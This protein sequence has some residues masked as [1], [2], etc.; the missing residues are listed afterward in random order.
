MSTVHN[1]SKGSLKSVSAPRSLQIRNNLDSE[2]PDVYTPEVLDALKALSVFNKDQKMLMEKRYARRAQRF[3]N[4]ERIRFLNPNDFIPRTNIKVQDARDGKFVGSEIPHDLQRQWIQGTGPAAKPK[5]SIEKSIRNVA[6]AL[7]SGADG[8]MFDGEDALGQINSMSLD[9]QRN[10]KLAIQKDPVFMN[11]AEQISRE[12]NDWA[13]GFFGK[14][15]IKDWRK[16]LDFTTKIFR[17]RGLHLD[18]RHIRDENGLALSASIVDAVLYVVNN[19][20]ELEKAGSSIVLYLPKIQTAEEAAFWNEILSALEDHLG[21]AIGSIKVY[22]LIEQLEA[23][24]Q[25]MEI[26]AALGRHFVGFNTG[27]WDYIN[28]VSDAMAWDSTFI[29]PNIES[30]TMTYGYMRNYEDRVRRAVNTPGVNKNYALWQGGMEP[31]IPVGTKKGVEEGMKKAVAGAVRE[32]KEGASGKWVAHW[33]MVHIVRPVWEKAGEDNQMGR[34]FPPLTYTDED[35]D[36]LTLL[37]PAPRTIRGARNLLSVG[38]QYGNAFGQGFQAAALKPADFF[39]N[40]DIL[41]LM[42]DAATGEIRLSILWEWIHKQAILNEDDKETGVKAGETFT[43]DLFERLL[44]EEYDK[45]LKAKDKDVHDDSK[46]TT[47]PIAREIVETYVLDDVKTPWYI[48]LMNINLNNYDLSTAKIRIKQYMDAFKKD[49]TRITE[50]LDFLPDTGL[51]TFLED[52]FDSFEREVQETKDYFAR[53]RFKGIRRLYS[54]R[55]VVQQRGTLETDYTVARRYSGEFYNRLRELYSKGEQI[56]SFGPYSPGQIVVMKRIGIEGIYLGGWA[57]SAKGSLDEDPGPDLASYPLSQVPDEAAVLVR[58]LLT[59]DR[60]QKFFRSRMSEKERKATPKVDYRPFIIA[61]ADTGHGGDAHVRNLVRRFVEVGVTGYHIEDQKPGTKKCG[62][63]GGKVLVPVDEQIKRLNAARFQLDIM[64]VPGIIVARTDAEAA[65]LL[66]G[67]GDERDHPFILGATNS[68]VPG[69]KNCYLAILKR[70]YDKGITDVNG[71]MLYKISDEEYD[72]AYE[73]FDKVGLT[74]IID[75]SIQ[76]LKEGMERS[77]TK[78]LDNAATKFVETWEIESGLTTYAQAVADEMEFQIEEGRPL[79]MTVDEWFEFANH[80]SFHHARERARSMGIEAEWDCELSRTPEGYYQVKGGIEYAIA[81][82]LAVA[83]YADLIWMETKTANYEEAREFAEAVHAVY[84]D[85]MLAYNLSPSFNWDTTG[86][87][88]D[89]MRN[90]PKEIG[91]LGFVFNFI[92]YGGHQVDGLASEEFATALKQDGMLALARLQRKLRLLDSPYRTPQSL[93]GGPRLDGAL[94]ASS[95]RTAT[96][97]AMGKGSTQVQH[98]VETEVPPRLLEGWLEMWSEHYGIP[99]RLSVKLRPHTAGSELLELSVTDE[100]NNKIADVIFTTIHDRWGSNFLSV[101]DQNTFEEKY[102]QK[103][104][105]ALIHLF[106]IHRYKAVSVH[107]V[108]P[109]EDNQKQA[110][111]MKALGIYDEV[112]TEVGHIIAAHV[113]SERVKELLGSDQIELKNFIA[114]KS[115]SKVKTKTAK[116]KTK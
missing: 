69:Y 2:Y 55:Q 59:A 13:K 64:K 116:K 63:Q 18:D 81:K 39:G 61:D 15:I 9:N 11:T 34:K 37:E 100:M 90:F 76:A 85:K 67:R 6:Y 54:A 70:F 60:N 97:K 4:K 82:S 113:N 62:H 66:D 38:L 17:A 47:L 25:L 53:P 30:I 44:A 45:L 92:T 94:S 79:D 40:D 49:G 98:L 42:E 115:K 78:P 83:P 31:N 109:T 27:R 80:T 101:R 86:M 36:G 43:Q 1:L 48:D 77:I 56:T 19:Y 114:K 84:P 99:G 41:Y 7:L 35:G 10:L 14:E 5:T 22:V 95:G 52:E 51:E 72:E 21:I 32:Q 50:N 24:F 107:Y 29:N 112:N 104:L 111:G 96:T 46:P 73:W 102:R 57:T 108:S 23:T 75:K 103:R 87:S 58:A 28:S 16:Q 106:L 110:E 71:F 91:K 33:K 20:K 74:P 3:R 88:E 105:M 89:E 8:W 26:R 65:T 12:M 68:N 93:V